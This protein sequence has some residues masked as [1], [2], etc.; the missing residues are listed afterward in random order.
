MKKKVLSI[1]IA[2]AVIASVSMFTGCEDDNQKSSN[3]QQEQQA[4]SNQWNIYVTG[5]T[6][7]AVMAGN[8]L[9][10]KSEFLDSRTYGDI[11]TN[12]FTNSD[13]YNVTCSDVTVSVNEDPSEPMTGNIIINA[14]CN[15]GEGTTY[16]MSVTMNWSATDYGDH[17]NFK[18]FNIT[19]NG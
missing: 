18:W 1:L 19:I 12:G 16:P 14:N 11:F 9:I 7:L 6:D 3:S 13:D 10:D 15:N 17:I 5:N 4:P 2:I 8:T